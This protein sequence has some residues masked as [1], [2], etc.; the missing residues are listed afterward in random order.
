MDGYIVQQVLGHGQL[1]MVLTILDGS[2]CL[3]ASGS[4]LIQKNL[5]IV[6]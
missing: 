2:I 1:K 5:V 6:C 3:T 4:I